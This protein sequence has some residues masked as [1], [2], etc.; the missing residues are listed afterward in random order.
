[1]YLL[2]T[3]ILAM[4]NTKCCGCKRHS[5]FIEGKSSFSLKVL[6]HRPADYR[7]GDI[8][9][10]IRNVWLTT[11]CKYLCTVCNE[12]AMEL[13]DNSDGA[14]LAKKSRINYNI[15]EVISDIESNKV[16]KEDLL[17]VIEKQ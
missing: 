12:R 11:K 5:E 13:N 3:V 15:N 9:F 16:P 10:L 8:D 7:K 14:S 1:M 17:K 6:A 4:D 2:V